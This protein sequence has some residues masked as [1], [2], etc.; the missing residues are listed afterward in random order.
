MREV[1]VAMQYLADV[2]TLDLKRDNCTGCGRCTQVCPHGVF[3]IEDGKARI[4]DRDVC[5]ECGACQRNCPAGALSVEAGV[6]CAYALLFADRRKRRLLPV[7]E[8][9]KRE[10]RALDRRRQ[11]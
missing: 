3:T 4:L 7:S 11:G 5:M 9:E 8:R 2:V 10:E 6:G 1:L